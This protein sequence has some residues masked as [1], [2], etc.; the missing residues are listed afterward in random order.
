MSKL[1]VNLKI[2]RKTSDLLSSKFAFIPQKPK[3][4]SR[5]IGLMLGIGNYIKTF[6]KINLHSL[7]LINIFK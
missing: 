5:Y 1:D 3:F 6:L 2:I 7:K 4:T